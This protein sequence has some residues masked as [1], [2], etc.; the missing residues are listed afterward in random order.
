M[1]CAFWWY[2]H[3]CSVCCRWV[4]QSS[5]KVFY[6]MFTLYLLQVI[7]AFVYFW[8]VDGSIV[9]DVSAGWLVWLHLFSAKL[10]PTRHKWG[11]KSQEVGEVEKGS[12]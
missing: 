9:E 2:A 4:L 7:T 6:V 5:R 10:S 1:L 12:L 3:R 8:N 11:P